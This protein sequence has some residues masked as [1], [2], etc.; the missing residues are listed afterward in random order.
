MTVGN[1]GRGGI[2]ESFAFP[3]IQQSFGMAHKNWS[4]VGRKID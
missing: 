1:N 4:F 3:V 2:A